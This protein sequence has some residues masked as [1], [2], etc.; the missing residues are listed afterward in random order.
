[1]AKINNIAMHLDDPANASIDNRRV[2]CGDAYQPSHWRT[3]RDLAICLSAGEDGFFPQE[4]FSVD[5]W[6]GL[7]EDEIFDV[8]ESNGWK[9]KNSHSWLNLDETYKTYDYVKGIIK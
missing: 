9:T 2:N 8:Y 1:M 6:P 5:E 7:E 4:G 3:P